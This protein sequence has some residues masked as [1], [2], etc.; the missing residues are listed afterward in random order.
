MSKRVS[1]IR[2]GMRADEVL[3]L[4]GRSED[5]IVQNPRVLGNDDHGLVVKWFYGDCEITLKHDGKVYR[6]AEIEDKETA[7]AR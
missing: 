1:K 4:R 7:A 6:V 3:K 5:F 2:I